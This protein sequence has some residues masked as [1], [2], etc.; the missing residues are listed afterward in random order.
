MKNTEVERIE[1]Y[2]L[3][4]TKNQLKKEAKERGQTLSGYLNSIIAERKKD[5]DRRS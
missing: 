1:F 3:T 4:K 2:V 5:E